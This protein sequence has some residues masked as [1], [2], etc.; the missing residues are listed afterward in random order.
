MSSEVKNDEKCVSVVLL[1]AGAPEA[2]IVQLPRD[3]QVKRQK[4]VMELLLKNLTKSSEAPEYWVAPEYGLVHKAPD[5]RRWSFVCL[6]HFGKAD[7][8]GMSN[9][10]YASHVLNRANVTG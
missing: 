10:P 1:R 6:C 3:D 8:Y 5:D 2:E 9:N 7:A 4:M